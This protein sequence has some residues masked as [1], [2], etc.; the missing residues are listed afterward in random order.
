MSKPTL[1][2]ISG[3][4]QVGKSTLAK[5]IAEFLI[6][7]GKSVWQ[8]EFSTQ[9]IDL[10]DRITG[11]SSVHTDK[12]KHRPALIALGKAMNEYDNYFWSK[13]L[14][15]NHAADVVIC[16][17]ARTQSQIKY[18]QANYS[19]IHISFYAEAYKG[20]AIHLKEK[21]SKQQANEALVEI[22]ALLGLNGPGSEHPVETTTKQTNEQR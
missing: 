13:A 12:E 21:P 17:G 4:D 16:C 2:I 5:T 22:S 15:I 8:V 9:I 1:I 3:P 19:T 14:P 20:C 10:L 11:D 18:L 6:Q 7:R